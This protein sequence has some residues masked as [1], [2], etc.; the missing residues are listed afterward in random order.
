MRF[1]IWIDVEKLLLIL[2]AKLTV[3]ITLLTKT[4]LI[5]EHIVCAIQQ[6]STYTVQYI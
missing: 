2:K 4:I 6:A 5:L 3:S 1:V